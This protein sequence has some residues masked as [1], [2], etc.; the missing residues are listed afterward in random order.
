MHA[1]RCWQPCQADAGW[2]MLATLT[3]ASLGCKGND[4]CKLTLVGLVVPTDTRVILPFGEVSEGTFE[5]G[6]RK[7]LLMAPTRRQETIHRYSWPLESILLSDRSD[8]LWKFDALEP[9]SECCF[10]RLAKMCAS[11]KKPIAPIVPN[12]DHSW[13]HGGICAAQMADGPPSP[14]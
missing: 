9:C 8:F 6:N 11:P 2:S 3:S 12:T 7:S 1:C 14:K 5:E 10:F 4:K 13:S